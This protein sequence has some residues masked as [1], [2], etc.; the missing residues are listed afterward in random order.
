MSILHKMIARSAKA[1]PSPEAPKQSAL[2]RMLAKTGKTESD[3]SRGTK[4]GRIFRRQGVRQSG[5][6]DRVLNIP[7]RRWEDKPSLHIELTD[8]LKTP[9]GTM[10]LRPVQAAALSD[11]HDWKGLV[12]PIRVGAGKCVVGETEIYDSLTGNRRSAK[13]PGPLHTP[14]FDSVGRIESHAAVA[15]PSGVKH[16]VCVELASGQRVTLSS[17]HPVR[18]PNGW[19]PVGELKVKDLVA[20]PRHLPAPKNHLL[21]SDYEVSLVAYLMADGGTTAGIEFT[22]MNPAVLEDFSRIANTL[23]TPH[24]QW[25]KVGVRNKHSKTCGRATT[26]SAR[27]IH[28]IV[29][30]WGLRARAKDKRLPAAMYGLPDEQIALFLNKFWACDGYLDKRWGAGVMLASEKL[31]DDL[32]FLLLRI[33]VMS[34]KHFKLA[35]CEGKTFPAWRLSISGNQ[36]LSFL[37]AVGEIIGKEMEC[38]RLREFIGGK[39]RNT[40]VDIVPIGIA[41]FKI[42]CDELGFP[43]KGQGIRSKETGRI[44]K[45]GRARTNARTFMSIT[46]GQCVS[47]EIFAKFCEEYSYRGRYAWLAMSDFAWERVTKLTAVGERE[48]FDL[49]VPAAGNFIA[50]GVVVHNT[51]ISLLAAEVLDAKRPLLLIPAKLKRKTEIEIAQLS[52]HWRFRRP[53]IITY[54]W[55]GRVQA[56]EEKNDDGDVVRSGFLEKLN[57]DLIISDECHKLKNKKAAVTRRVGRFMHANPGVSFVG[58]SGTITKRSLRDY[59]HI[60]EWALGKITPLPLKW[61]VL[62]EWAD[63]LDEKVPDGARLAPGALVKFCDIEEAKTLQTDSLSS[64]RRAF[65]RRLVETPGV[66]ATTE[67]FVDCSIVISADSC[68]F[69]EGIDQAFAMLRSDWVTPDGWPVPDPISLWRHARE[70]ACGFHYTWSP[71]PP[72]DWLIARKEWCAA[73]RK[74]IQNGTL[75]SELQVAQAVA[76]GRVKDPKGVYANWMVLKDTFKP[77]TVPV[78][79]DDGCLEFCRWWM[80]ENAGLVWVEH[81]AFGEKLA[82][83]TGRPFFHRKGVDQTGRL[84]DQVTPDGGAVIASIAAN[85]EGRNLQA[86]NKNLIVSVPPSGAILEQ[87]LG[88]THR[89]GQQADEVTLD[90]LMSCIEQWSGFQQ[91]LA[92]A[93]YIEDSTGQPQKLLYADLDVPGSHE[94]AQF[95]GPR[96]ENKK[97]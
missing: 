34:R 69:G 8:W 44:Q 59:A 56:G 86:W 68:K 95:G 67:G 15:A 32:R 12:A 97:A 82:A 6:L 51:L 45:Y 88:R 40:N 89:D 19:C 58:M 37:D 80:E 48:V 96:W 91:A 26:L 41:E 85:C 11:I 66:V 33:G 1:D 63:A 23:A 4:L 76:A 10:E 29:N 54:E 30:Y 28:Q 16:C 24:R 25:T 71:R 72:A 64:I 94:V 22:N 84:I 93:K 60:A 74:I 53:E 18:V 87:L 35:K 14:A 92:D 3:F 13:E 17:D 73:V 75:D 21:C 43:G 78:W 83:Y 65:R 77:N 7:R 5:E 52:K 31:I 90:V 47:R 38:R 46:S 62:T 42:I 27:G 57:P 55:L 9:A 20:V 81:V 39:K 2:Q 70:I 61:P 79:I 49:S 36:V 50:D